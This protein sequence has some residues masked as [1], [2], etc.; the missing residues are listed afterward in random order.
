M[1]LEGYIKSCWCLVLRAIYC[2]HKMKNSFKIK[3]VNEI[4]C[5]CTG[6]SLRK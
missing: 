5:T 1:Y 6:R 2:I 3:N 4:T